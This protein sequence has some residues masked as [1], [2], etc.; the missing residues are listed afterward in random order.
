MAIRYKTRIEVDGVGEFEIEV[1]NVVNTR[2]FK[3][4]QLVPSLM[5]MANV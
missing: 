4:R 5:N 2:T 1:T 3:E